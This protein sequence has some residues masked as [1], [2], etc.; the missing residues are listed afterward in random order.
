MP[1]GVREKVQQGNVTVSEIDRQRQNRERKLFS[2][3]SRYSS[4]PDRK[5]EGK[6]QGNK[7][8]TN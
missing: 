7:N 6:G 1:D 3:V 2:V 5:K 4:V 8:R